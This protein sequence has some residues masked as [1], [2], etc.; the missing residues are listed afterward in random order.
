[1]TAEPGVRAALY[2]VPDGDDP[3]WEAGTRWLGRDPELGIGLAQPAVPGIG[4]LT[5]A[6]RRYGFHATLRPPMRLA[7]GWEAFLE[8][9]R[10][11]A[12]AAEPF[13]LPALVVADLDGFLAL[14][15]AAPCPALQALA[16]A[17][18]RGT[19]A[20]RLAASAD[21]LARRRAAGLSPVQEALLVRW[22]YPYVMEAWRFHM[23]LSRRLEAADMA[24]LRPAA[25]A[26]FAGALGVARLV[27]GIAVFT[28]R[29]EADF[30]I[31]TRIPFGRV[32]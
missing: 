2:W 16:E 30:L 17:C 13:A 24:R 25:E 27:T 6:P 26:H 10:A 5:Q 21:E 14:R 28:Q 11:V 9:A 4:A 32:G 22:G 19:E 23:T 20:H 31:A 8:S 12:R 29:G 18:V 15:E 3:L 1:M 7:T